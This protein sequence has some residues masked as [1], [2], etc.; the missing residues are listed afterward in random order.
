M[1]CTFFFLINVDEST[2]GVNLQDS[3]FNKCTGFE[4][5]VKKLKDGRQMCKDFE[6]FLRQRYAIFF[7]IYRFRVTHPLTVNFALVIKNTV[8][9]MLL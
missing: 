4:V 6:D 3:D 2:I 5:L 1:Y 9:K 7:N 8:P